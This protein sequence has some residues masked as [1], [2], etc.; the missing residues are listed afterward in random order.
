M[1]KTCKVADCQCQK[2]ERLQRLASSSR[3][4][5]GLARSNHGVDDTLGLV[6]KCKSF[7][8]KQQETITNISLN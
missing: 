4:I 3:H 7:V 2:D 8:Y 1:K 6:C 5:Y